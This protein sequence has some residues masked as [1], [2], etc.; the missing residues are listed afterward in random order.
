MARVDKRLE[1]FS[2]AKT[3]R[4]KDNAAVD[5]EETGELRPGEN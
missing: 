1:E 2:A 5:N 3:R 4:R